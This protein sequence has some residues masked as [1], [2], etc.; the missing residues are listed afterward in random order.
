MAS[1]S[2]PKSPPDL[3]RA[4]TALREL[5]DWSQ[6]ELAQAAG[7]SPNKM[8]DY[9]RGWRAVTRELLETL[10][11]LMGFPPD[12]VDQAV[13]FVRSTRPRLQS[14][15]SPGGGDGG[16]ERARIER[17]ALRMGQIS[18][19][20]TRRLL[21]SLTYEGQAIEARR[22]APSLWQRMK[23]L[24]S[25]QRRA[26]VEDAP[27]FRS[28]ALCELICKESKKAAADSASRA[29][30]LAE[31]ALL[32]AELAPG[33]ASWRQRLQGY[34]W[35]HVGNARRVG[36]DLP[37]ADEAFVCGSEL[38]ASG[39]SGD[40]GFLD[41][42]QVLSLEAS[43]RTTQGCLLEA[44]SLLERA[45]SS[46]S[47]E[48]RLNLLIKKARVFEWGGN[49]ESA[50][51]TL[52]EAAP[53][54]IRRDEP[55]LLWMLKLNSAW[56]LTHLARYS[57][58]EALLPEIRRLT[59]G[60]NN[61]LDTLRLRWL[62]GRILAGLGKIEAALT[63]LFQVRTNFAERGIAY[64]AALAT[65]EVAALQLE[66]ARTW[67]VKL[68]ARQM[69]PIFQTQGLHREAL[70]ALKLFCEAAENEMATVELARRVVAY[71]YRARHNPA[72]RFEELS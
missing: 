64:D 70:A 40:P 72:L 22:K 45:L 5:A 35:A 30:E 44:A 39:A 56:N 9:E 7:V 47:L 50:L 63:A 15:S 54:I 10:A 28:W 8:S 52:A 23:G 19:E 42:A 43:L 32:I 24:P 46:A 26:L 11:G 65:L 69:A 41:K 17:L 51:V 48:D 53:S 31:L 67:D 34:A 25:S 68:L 21:T 2:A 59:L 14:F 4:L 71:L 18:E 58:A 12:A 3:S 29:R 55:R 27:E 13:H 49:Y 16:D 1:K 20:S 66:R 57:E 61:E 62:E 38:W 37:G 33:E 36:G 60:L 6:V